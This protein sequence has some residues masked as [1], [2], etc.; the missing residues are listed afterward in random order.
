MNELQA[1]AETL[2]RWIEPAPGVTVY[3]FGSRVRGQH[4]GDSDVD[5]RLFQSEW[6]VCDAT[7]QWWRVQNETGFA[8]IKSQLPGVLHIHADQN[9]T[10]DEHIRKGMKNP[11]LMV[12]RVVCVWTPKRI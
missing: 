1:L 10:P 2:A 3:L 7:A 6:K 4:H 8:E 12:G 11:V 9:D 5:I